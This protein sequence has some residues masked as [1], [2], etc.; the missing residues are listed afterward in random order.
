MAGLHRVEES[1]QHVSPLPVGIGDQSPLA[2]SDIFAMAS[3]M[4]KEFGF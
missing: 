1:G 2:D 4:V 3:S